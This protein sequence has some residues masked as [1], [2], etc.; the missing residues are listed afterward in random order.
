MNFRLLRIAFPLLFTLLWVD[1]VSAVECASINYYLQSQADVDA[2]GA[3][4]CD[5]VRGYL[6]I[7]DSSD[8]ANLDSLTNIISVGGRLQISSNTALSNLDGLAN[9]T[10]VG[11]YLEIYNNDALTNLDSLASLTSVGGNLDIWDNDALTNLN[12]LANITSVGGYLGIGDNDA[13]TNL[14]GLTNITSVG[15]SLTISHND[16]L[17]NLDSLARITSIGA[18]LTI[19][20]NDALTNLDGLASIT[21]LTGN[22]SIYRN[23]KASCE[24]VAQLL[25]WP[26]GPPADSVVG[27]IGIGDN[28]KG[29]DSVEQILASVSG[30]TQPVINQA[31]ASSASISLGFTPSTT[32]DTMFPITSYS[33]SCT[34]S[35][36]DVS[37]SP[38]TDLLDNTPILEVLTVTGFDPVSGPSSI[39]VDVDITHSDPADLYITL[40]SPQDTT[41]TIWD[42]GGAGGEN[43][44]GTFPT[45]LTPVDSLD[46]VASEAKDGDWILR[47]EDLDVGPIV[48]EGV[49]N[50]WGIGITEQV[51]ASGSSSPIQV[52]GITPRR[53]YQCRVA[54][55]TKLGKVPY[56]EPFIA[57]P[58][59]TRVFN[60]LL[61][62]VLL[63]AQSST[64]ESATSI[65][66]KAPAA[67]KAREG[68]EKPKS[69]PTMPILGF[70]ILSGLVGLFGIRQLANR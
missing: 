10:D 39:T 62:T 70:L 41:L 16:A 48:R 61:D 34:G 11:D 25:G 56:S 8:I 40:T 33:A 38:V 9:I 24:G 67:R 54:P 60:Q 20:H 22:L 30:P 66:P 23:Y 55:V 6:A 32:T 7:T 46:A 63:T 12:G 26:N 52:T 18:S 4:G 50:S 35:Q 58:S 2:L 14:D 69:I 29:C 13:L 36:A 57:N 47:V 15:D 31:T 21:S 49:L 37:G 59:V 3:T 42:R 51:T 17:T 53:E 64:D 5:T 44:V 65:A 28:G 68:Q 45:T 27:D 19:S 1:G 43:L